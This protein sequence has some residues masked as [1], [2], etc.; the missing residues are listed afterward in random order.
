M[1][2]KTKKSKLTDL[3]LSKN[4]QKLAQESILLCKEADVLLEETQ[5]VLDDLLEQRFDND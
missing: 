1:K 3:D 4:A 5:K 2:A